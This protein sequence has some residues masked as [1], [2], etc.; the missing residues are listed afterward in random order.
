M[1]VHVWV[2]EKKVWISVSPFEQVP[3]LRAPQDQVDRLRRLIFPSVM[4]GELA[5][6]PRRALHWGK[7]VCWIG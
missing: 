2:V 6:C 5:R 1:M 4:P 3:E 7:K